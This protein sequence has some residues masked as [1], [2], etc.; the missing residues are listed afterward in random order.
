[1]FKPFTFQLWY[2]SKYLITRKTW[3]CKLLT[4]E[5]YHDDYYQR[6][7]A[8]QMLLERVYV[9]IY[10]LQEIDRYNESAQ[11]GDRALPKGCF[12]VLG[13]ICELIKADLGLSIW[14]LFSDDNP[15]ANTIKSLGRFLKENNHNLISMGE[16]PKM[17]LPKTLRLSEERLSLLRKTFLA[18]ND[19]KKKPMFLFIFRI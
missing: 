15:R 11:G 8:L 18:H 4:S 19:A 12:Y 17:S 1:M 5:V 3:R 13:H 2:N 16:I 7:E 9:N 6:Y 14:K 10:A